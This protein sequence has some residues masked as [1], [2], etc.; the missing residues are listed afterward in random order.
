MR[1]IRDIE[2]IQKLEL[3][4]TAVALG[5]F[6]GVH[7]GHRMIMDRLCRAKTNGYISLVFTF[8]G[9]PNCRARAEEE[10]KKLFTEE[11]KLLVY[12][13]LGID[14]IIIYPLSSGILEM[15][16]E[17]FVKDILSEKL[18]AGLVICGENF[19]FGR[20]R[21][22]DAELL[23]E[24]SCHFGYTADIVPMM[25]LHDRV[26]SSTVIR[27]MIKRGD[28]AAAEEMLGHRYT[29]VG[30]VVHGNAIGRTLDTPTANIEP[31]RDKLLP[32]NG[33]YISCCCIDG[34]MYK[35]V[36]NIGCKPTVRNDGDVMGVETCFLDFDG[37]LYGRILEIELMCFTRPEKKF[38]GLSELKAQLEKDKRLG[39][40][41]KG[42]TNVEK[43][44]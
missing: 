3:K 11:E 20:G 13:K 25:K 37:D 18:G 12:E 9:N 5:K 7:K 44:L 1:V 6:D 32:P 40:E 31:D 39:R 4:N 19:R 27:D 2:E 17:T 10:E 23:S 26:I 24:L 16:P 8:S 35:G 36:T 42:L 41:Y 15:E 30:K 38:S 33:V 21:R 14:I 43:V 34:K 29:I 22:G 28:I